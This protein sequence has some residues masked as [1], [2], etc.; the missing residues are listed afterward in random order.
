VIIMAGNWKIGPSE[1]RV[2]GVLILAGIGVVAIITG[3]VLVCR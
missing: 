3:V 1:W 2:Y